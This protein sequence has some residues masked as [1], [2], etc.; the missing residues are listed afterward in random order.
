MPSTDF[1]ASQYYT[2]VCPPSTDSI[3]C[4]YKGKPYRW[5]GNTTLPTVAGNRP[6]VVLGFLDS[7]DGFLGRPEHLSFEMS[8]SASAIAQL[9]ISAWLARHGRPEFGAEVIPPNQFFGPLIPVRL[10]FDCGAEVKAT[11]DGERLP[12]NRR[13]ISWKESYC[14]C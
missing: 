13:K 8:P 6:R 2:R 7:T 12:G 1:R 10:C 14:G 3:V 11:M 9:K 5:I 4:L